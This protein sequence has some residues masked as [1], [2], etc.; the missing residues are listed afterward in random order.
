MKTFYNLY[1][2]LF[3][4]FNFQNILHAQSWSPSAIK[5]QEE[6][7]RNRH[8]YTDPI[9]SI[10]YVITL[11]ASSLFALFFAFFWCFYGELNPFNI[12]NIFR[13]VLAFIVTAGLFF[14]ALIYP[15]WGIYSLIFYIKKLL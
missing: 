5:E 12:I 7:D 6:Y 10:V 2:V 8:S 15:F 3:L 4:F 14:G 9:P 11:I 1:L 13:S